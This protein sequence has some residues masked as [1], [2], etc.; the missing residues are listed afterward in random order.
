MNFKQELRNHLQIKFGKT[1]LSKADITKLQSQI[2]S[3][4]AHRISE[5]TLRRFFNLIP[6]TKTSKTIL[7]IL[8]EFI[9][10]KDYN[11]FVEHCNI[12]INSILNNSSNTFILSELEKK[13]DISL[14]EVGLLSNHIINLIRGNDLKIVAKFFD[15]TSLYRL[16]SRNPNI[17][18][19]FGHSIGPIVE[20]S[21][22][23]PDPK[24]LLQTKYFIQL[25][26]FRYVDVGNDNISRY[27]SALLECSKDA[28]ERAFCRSV[29]ALN[30]VYKKDLTVARQ[31]YSSI[32]APGNE[33]S[34]Q[35][36]GRIALL[37]W[38][39]NGDD[40]KL[41]K[42][43]DEYADR[44]HFFSIDILQYLLSQEKHRMLRKWLKRYR[45]GL[46][47][48]EQW[49]KIELSRVVE[50]AHDI[51][52]HKGDKKQ[53]LNIQKYTFQGIKSSTIYHS[54]LEKI[55]LKA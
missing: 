17:H 42:I 22:F 9:G 53:Q 1:I 16:I 14:L 52:N 19:L 44:I 41:F 55:N 3:E 24:I 13:S 38:I 26:L 2:L 15:S 10:Y 12:K 5:S 30:A 34:P 47:S 28:I 45:E 50:A 27:L 54:F 18:E 49:V 23:V 35:L 48:N 31:I 29:L 32:E 33:L 25:V 51:L 43:A 11:S 6:S 46:I 37:E 21:E 36:A 7:D 4:T 40:D 39:L 8:S 20:N